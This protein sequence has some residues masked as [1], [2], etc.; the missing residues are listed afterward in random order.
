M[1][2]RISV[3]KK[4]KSFSLPNAVCMHSTWWCCFVDIWFYV[5]LS[6]FLF[7]KGIRS[8]P[9]FLY[10]KGNSFHGPVSIFKSR[11]V[12][13]L[14]T[15]KKKPSVSS[16]PPVLGVS[17]VF[18]RFTEK[19]WNNFDARKRM[20]W[21]KKTKLKK[22]KSPPWVKTEPLRLSHNFHITK[23]WIAPRDTLRVAFVEKKHKTA[24]FIGFVHKKQ[25]QNNEE[26]SWIIEISER[27]ML[28]MT[29]SKTL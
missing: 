1:T 8:V 26:Q 13:F 9:R 4:K 2:T 24:H 19:C 14:V 29:F 18:Q 10:V 23:R 20:D 5:M 17:V 3:H 6:A 7:E 25:E 28:Q 15:T 22:S 12:L 16:I 21:S 11:L 27:N